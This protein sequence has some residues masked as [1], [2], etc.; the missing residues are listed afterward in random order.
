M[1][2]FIKGVL[3]R[4]KIVHYQEEKVRLDE[5][6]DKRYKLEYQGPPAIANMSS[7]LRMVE[8]M[9]EMVGN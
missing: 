2:E 8:S 3:K 6:S 9:M 7:Y 5:V 4:D 1:T